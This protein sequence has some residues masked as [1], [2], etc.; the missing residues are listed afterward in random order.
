MGSVT[1]LKRRAGLGLFLGAEAA[2]GP[3]RV[4]AP[5]VNPSQET[6]LELADWAGERGAWGGLEGVGEGISSARSAQSAGPIAGMGEIG[7]TS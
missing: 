4:Q 1:T 3:S 5:L 2:A 7:W 6:G